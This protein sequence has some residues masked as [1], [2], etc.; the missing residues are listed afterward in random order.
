MDDTTLRGLYARAS[1]VFYAPYDEDY[2]LVTLEAFQSRKPVVTTS[3]AGGVLE[4]VH[5]GET[6][7]VA[8]ASAEAIG[9]RL[10]RL[11]R[12]KREA[13]RLGANGYASVQAI[14]WDEVVDKLTLTIR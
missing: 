13:R 3:D 1:A 9:E 10:A 7:C 4:F 8:P 11:L 14:G 12:D 2:G 5:D 6:G